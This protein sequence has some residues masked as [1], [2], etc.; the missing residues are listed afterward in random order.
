MPSN[1]ALIYFKGEEE[2]ITPNIYKVCKELYKPVLLLFLVS[3]D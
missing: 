1:Y 3:T 2:D